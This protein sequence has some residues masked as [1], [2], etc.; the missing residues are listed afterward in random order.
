MLGFF[1]TNLRL[2]FEL[3]GKKKL[4]CP[5]AQLIKHNAMK[6]YGGVKV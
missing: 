6:A 5:C 1:N 4:I 3:K 2:G